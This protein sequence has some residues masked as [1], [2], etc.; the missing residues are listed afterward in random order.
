MKYKHSEPSQ[1][2]PSLYNKYMKKGVFVSGRQ[3]GALSY[4]QYI[5][6]ILSGSPQ[7]NG[8]VVHTI[9][10][11]IVL[12]WWICVHIEARPNQAQPSLSQAKPSQAKQVPERR[13]GTRNIDTKNR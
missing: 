11:G 13:T 10:V 5:L 3:D 7:Y 9:W 6:L 12:S 4:Q 2:K 1:A 8:M